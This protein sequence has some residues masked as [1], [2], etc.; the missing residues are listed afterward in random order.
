MNPFRLSTL[1]ALGLAALAATPGPAAANA[2]FCDGN[3]FLEASMPGRSSDAGTDVMVQIRNV[4]AQTLD[5]SFALNG[6][7]PG[8]RLTGTGVV[9][10]PGE[11]FLGVI[12]RQNTSFGA[13]PTTAELATLLGVTC[14]APWSGWDQR[15]GR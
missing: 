5:V 13:L 11:S 9:L 8:F 10:S 7:R 15:R 14:G 1:A 12:G 6:A 2:S 3:L 4:S